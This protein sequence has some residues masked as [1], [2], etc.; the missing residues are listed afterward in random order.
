LP[1]WINYW[2]IN[3]SMHLCLSNHRFR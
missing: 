3:L 1:E 2:G